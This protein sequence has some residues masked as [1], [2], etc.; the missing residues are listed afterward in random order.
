MS[1]DNL[2]TKNSF[3]NYHFI[4]AINQHTKMCVLDLKYTCRDYTCLKNLWGLYDKFIPHND[5]QH[6]VLFLKVSK[7]CF[8]CQIYLA[9]LRVLHLFFLF[10]SI[11][12]VWNP[13]YIY[14]GYNQKTI[15]FLWRV[16]Q[17]SFVMYSV[18]LLLQLE[19]L[20]LIYGFI[21]Y[22]TELNNR[23]KIIKPLHFN[24]TVPYLL[25]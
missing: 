16:N 23:Y 10:R 7:C 19:C 9:P 15:S 13:I 8:V 14:I 18:R 12:T 21:N 20:V 22:K 6:Y 25:N 4:C 24:Q 1:E 2:F 11:K 3:P 5:M 17:S